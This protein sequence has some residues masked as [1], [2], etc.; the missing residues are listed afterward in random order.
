MSNTGNLLI[1]PTASKSVSGL[2]PESG[3]AVMDF[4]DLLFL[5]LRLLQDHAGP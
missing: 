1:W 3:P 2:R 4:D 5:W